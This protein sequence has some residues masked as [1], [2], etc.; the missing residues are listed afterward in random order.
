VSDNEEMVAFC[1][2]VHPRLVGVL[3]FTVGDR[4]VA[5]ELA[6]ETVIRICQ[7]WPKVRDMAAP[8]AWSHRVALNLANSWLRRRIA[9][10]KATAKLQSRPATPNG[11]DSADV[12][13]VR[14]AVAQLPDRQRTALVLRY[15][16][17]LP[18][19]QAATVMGCKE[20]TV[21]ALT[22]QAIGTLR[23]HAGL[24]DLEEIVDAV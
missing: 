12:L 19:A 7:Q 15:F 5:E 8:D 17:D 1:R 18:A 13:A 24:L 4:W 14:G 16:A 9:E 21:R 23:D 6:Q 2:R 3:A 22:Y 11:V 20:S 10:R